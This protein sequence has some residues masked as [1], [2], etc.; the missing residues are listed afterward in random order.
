MNPYHIIDK[1]ID[2]FK[3]DEAPDEIKAFIAELETF[4]DGHD[5]DRVKTRIEAYIEEWERRQFFPITEEG[6]KRLVSRAEELGWK[7]RWARLAQSILSDYKEI[8]Q[9]RVP[10]AFHRASEEPT[11]HDP[12]YW[13]G[14]GKLVSSRAERVSEEII[15][16]WAMLHS[17]L[18]SAINGS[19]SETFGQIAAKLSDQAIA[20]L[21]VVEGP[22]SPFWREAVRRGLSLWEPTP[23]L[24]DARARL[25]REKRDHEIV[26]C[27]DEAVEAGEAFLEVLGKWWESLPP[28]KRPNVDVVAEV[29]ARYIPFFAAPTLQRDEWGRPTPLQESIKNVLLQKARS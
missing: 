17:A 13:E 22:Y 19:A 2:G 7:G 27:L 10:G 14:L 23:R 8:V 26:P 18:I 21:A 25:E 9:N 11:V 16:H 24:R 5:N 4:L 6:L 1:Y 29:A 28:Q 15:Y 20:W 3:F 12:Y